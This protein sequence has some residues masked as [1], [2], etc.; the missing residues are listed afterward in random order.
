MRDWLRALRHNAGLTMG[1]AAEKLD[2][3]ESYYCRIE[4]GDRL[5]KL[6]MPLA[7]KISALFGVQLDEIAEFEG[8]REEETT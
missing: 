8:G 2:L 5:K 7:K 6:D 3:T 1:Q 4:N